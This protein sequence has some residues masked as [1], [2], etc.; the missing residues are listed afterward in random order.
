MT[1]I[2]VSQK[3]R[4]SSTGTMPLTYPISSRPAA[5]FLKSSDLAFGFMTKRNEG[6]PKL[7]TV[8]YC[9]TTAIQMLSL[10]E[11]NNVFLL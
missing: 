3:K 4:W 11:T 5:L 6:W 8:L 7:R 2:R 10:S 1:K 9:V